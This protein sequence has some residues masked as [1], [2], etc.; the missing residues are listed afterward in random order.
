MRQF[1][2]SEIPD[3][4]S[5]DCFFHVIPAPMEKSVSYGE[6]TKRGPDAILEASYQLEAF[7]GDGCPCNLGIYTHDTC[8]DLQTIEQEVAGVLKNNHFPVVLGGEHTVTL[9]ALRAL[10]KA[11]I[12]FGIVQFDAHADLRNEYEGSPLSHACVMR[13]AIDDLE[14]PLYQIGV[15]ALSLEE[16]HLRKQRGITHLDARTIAAT[17]IPTT[18]LPDDFPTNIYI[19]FDVDALDSSLMPATGT[20]EPGGLTWREAIL[21]LERVVAGRHVIGADFVELAPLD[22]LHAPD[23][24]VARLVYSCM[25]LVSRNIKKI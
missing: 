10:K 22:G 25:G 14:L 12:E 17:G 9:G 13:R 6:G 4:K 20:P 1:L 16:H 2:E 5:E 11:R 3:I 21:A 18:L 15:R 7:D 19:T 24:T 23:Y 8:G